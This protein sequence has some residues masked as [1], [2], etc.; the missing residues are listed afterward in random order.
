[1]QEKNQFI[2]NYALVWYLIIQPNM[3]FDRVAQYKRMIGFLSMI[4]ILYVLFN[5][6]VSNLFIG[7][8]GLW[9]ISY[10]ICYVKGMEYW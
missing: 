9:R 1:M 8:I 10:F 5:S 4:I 3:W 2:E 7:I 6:V